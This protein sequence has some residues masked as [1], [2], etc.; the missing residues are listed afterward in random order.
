M[1]SFRKPSPETLRAVLESQ[2]GVK[3]TYQE[4]GA[5]QDQQSPQGFVIDH[6]RARLGEGKEVFS[7][8]K[9]GLKRW[10]QYSFPWLDAWPDDTPIRAGNEVATV[11]HLLGFWWV[12]VCRIV[13]TIDEPKRFGYAYGTVPEHVEC[14]EERF[15]VELTESG[16]VWYDIYAFSRPQSW[17]ARIGYP[18]VRRIQKLFGQ[19][20]V[21]ALKIAVQEQR[22][23]NRVNPRR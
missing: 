1:F 19:Y 6:T 11:A 17:L 18:Y 5:T 4:V 22:L 13:Y 10:R 12:N 14:G 23:E 9:A 2:K 7:A 21:A 16:E 20:S 15:L 3:L 8:A